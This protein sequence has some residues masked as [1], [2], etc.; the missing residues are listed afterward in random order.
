MQETEDQ[1]FYNELQYIYANVSST[2]DD[3][4]NKVIDKFF[5]SP[6]LDDRTSLDPL[7]D[8]SYIFFEKANYNYKNISSYKVDYNQYL[9]FK[10][11]LIVTLIALSIT[12]LVGFGIFCGAPFLVGPMILP[13]V[14]A[15]A[16]AITAMGILL[17]GSLVVK[18]AV[19]VHN[20]KKNN[21]HK[22]ASI[23]NLEK[24]FIKSEIIKAI[25]SPNE[26][27]VQKEQSKVDFKNPAVQALQKAN[28]TQE[29]KNTIIAALKKTQNINGV[30]P[31][32]Q[33]GKFVAQKYLNQLRC[34]KHDTQITITNIKSTDQ[35]AIINYCQDRILDIGKLGLKQD[36]YK[37]IIKSLTNSQANNNID[38]I[39]IT[40]EQD[41]LTITKEGKSVTIHDIKEDNSNGIKRKIIDH[42][43]L[44]IKI[45]EELEINKKALPIDT[46]S[47]AA[48]ILIDKMADKIFEEQGRNV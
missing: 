43:N 16:I 13:L 34:N 3:Y 28:L 25:N 12:T 44:Q 38:G 42:C 15:V 47:K 37:N 10:K 35:E 9:D 24:E 22:L 29:E 19:G 21:Y 23:A 27:N 17:A 11:G 14:K 30:Y 5:P 1:K 32:H 2:N 45:Q 31:Q 36:D 8:Q 39:T 33:F 18:N 6:L 46:N 26:Q 41:T 7:I 48:K 20:T 40:L 4:K